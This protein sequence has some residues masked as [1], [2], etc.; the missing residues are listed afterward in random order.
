LDV[1]SLCRG[2]REANLNARG[3]SA[4]DEKRI[5]DALGRGLLKEFPNPE[6]SECPGSDVL[7]RIASRTMPLAEA[8]KWLDHLGSCSPCYKDFSELRKVRE[9]QRKRT[10]FAFAASILVAVGI[11]GWV[12]IRRHSETLVAQTAVIDLRSR[13]VSRS[14]EP[15]PREQP[16]ELRRGFSQLN[17]YLPLGSPEGGYEVRIVTTSGD[18][19]L[20]TG[21][22]ARLEDGVTS[23][24]VRGRLSPV[25]PGQCIMQIR[26]PPS[27]WTSYP[28]VLR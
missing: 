5:L 2:L 27:E 9:V 3:Y 8:G 21:G 13:S 10:L 11:G 18:S 1:Y 26:K 22:A 17:I 15:N 23:L 19:L 14:P 7:K 12:L 28:L 4:G 24:Q 25:R 6:R 20:N 16:L